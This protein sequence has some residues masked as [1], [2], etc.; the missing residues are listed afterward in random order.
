M[1]SLES[2]TVDQ[3]PIALGASACYIME[4]LKA[5]SLNSDRTSTRDL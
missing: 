2:Q 1:M 3:S 5:Q 4:T